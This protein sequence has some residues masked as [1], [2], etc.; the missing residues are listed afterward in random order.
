MMRVMREK[1]ELRIFSNDVE[2]FPYS[3]GE[4]LKEEKIQNDKLYTR[5]YSEIV[6]YLLHNYI[7]SEVTFFGKWNENEKQALVDLIKFVG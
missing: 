7:P 2:S 6:E 1:K 3:I 4:F 5:S